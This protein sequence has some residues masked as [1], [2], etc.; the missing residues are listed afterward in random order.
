MKVPTLE[1]LQLQLHIEE[2]RSVVYITT[3]ER[4]PVVSLLG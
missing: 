2:L 4:K 1:H 3:K